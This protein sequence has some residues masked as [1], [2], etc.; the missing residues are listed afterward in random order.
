MIFGWF[1]RRR[2][3]HLH[4][5]EI[6]IGGFIRQVIYDTLL[7]NSEQ[8]ASSLG[9]PPISPDVEEMEEKASKRR[10]EE[11]EAIIPVIASHAD[12]T[13]QIAL[14]SFELNGGVSDPKLEEAFKVLS[15]S[16]AL[17][18]V[19]TLKELGLIELGEFYE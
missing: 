4:V 8:I 13:T 14:A 7:T 11:I 5:Q 1:R 15:F 17:S 19:S 18:C 10:L 16:S 3:V 2:H 12:I 6:S 9:L